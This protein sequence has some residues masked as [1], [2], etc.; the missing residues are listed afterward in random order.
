MTV[1]A[2][3]LN[4]IIGHYI[5]LDRS[6]LIKERQV[7][8]N[9]TRLISADRYSLEEKKILEVPYFVDTEKAFDKEN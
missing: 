5:H 7:V 9:T 8:W 3:R 1:G 6:C 2:K 4:K